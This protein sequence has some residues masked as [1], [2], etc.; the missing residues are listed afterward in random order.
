[1]TSYK[2]TVVCIPYKTFKERCNIINDLIDE[3][4]YIEYTDKSVIGVKK[5]KNRRFKNEIGK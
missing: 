3:D 2:N 5:P 1:M 4:Y